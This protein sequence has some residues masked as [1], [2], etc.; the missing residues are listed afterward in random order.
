MNKNG[1]E[2]GGQTEPG[3]LLSYS[4]SGVKDARV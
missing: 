3:S 1:E 4:R 2:A